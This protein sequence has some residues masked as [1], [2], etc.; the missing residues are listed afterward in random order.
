[1][2]RYMF[3]L[4]AI[5]PLKGCRKSALK[6]LKEGLMYYFCNDYVITE[7]G[8]CMRDEYVRPLPEDFFSIKGSSNIQINVSA[9]VGMNGDGKSS[10]VELAMRLINNCAKHYRL[11]DKD[12]LLRIEG[13]KAELYYLLDDVVYCIRE[14]NQ[15]SL[16]KYADISNHNVRQWKK[17]ET[18]VKSVSRMNE[19]FYTIVSNYS[20]YAYNT[21]DFRD[22]WSE[23]MQ[24]TEECWKCWLHYLFH[25]NDG[26]RTPMTI[27]PYRYEGNTDI[28]KETELTMQRLMNLRPI[29]S[30]E[31][32]HMARLSR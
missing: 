24:T 19:L 14:D 23:K 18:P 29:R 8:I 21:K 22:E 17:L 25:K 4:I 26:Y 5:R 28:N 12:N 9:V 20:L 2:I 30:R 15:I 3:K 16:L 1:M 32:K 31:R 11:T 27:H 13:I 6:C 10:L 7:D